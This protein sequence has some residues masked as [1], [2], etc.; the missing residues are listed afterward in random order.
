MQS[1]DEHR[2]DHLIDL[3]AVTEETKGGS[4]VSNDSAG[5]Q[6]GLPGLSDD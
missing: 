5:Q 2:E 1:I 4:I 3:G 6:Q